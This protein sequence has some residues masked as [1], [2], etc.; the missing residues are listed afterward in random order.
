MPDIGM[1]GFGNTE[2]ADFDKG[3]SAMDITNAPHTKQTYG[4]SGLSS[5]A[6]KKG[7]LGV[8]N[9]KGNDTLMVGGAFFVAGLLSKMMFDRFVK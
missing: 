6:T 5:P 9:W 3:S 1:A 7:R 4:L 2:M 8:I